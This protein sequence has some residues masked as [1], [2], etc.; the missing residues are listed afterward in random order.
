MV[1]FYSPHIYFLSHSDIDSNGIIDREELTKCLEKLQFDCT[2]QEINDLFE[3]CDL[4]RNKGM[5]FNEFVVVLCLIYLLAGTPSS[6]HTVTTIFFNLFERF[7]NKYVKR[8]SWFRQ[9]QW[10][11]QSLQQHL[12]P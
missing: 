12:I 1:S 3:S 9:Q 4:G 7:L 10:D 2:E 11:L 8:F 6:S 5:K